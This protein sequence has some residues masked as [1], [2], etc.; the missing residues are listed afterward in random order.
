MSHHD[1]PSDATILRLIDGEC[2]TSERH[3]AS[4][5]LE[6]CPSCAQKRD[7]FARLTRRLTMTAAL[8]GAPAERLAARARLQARLSAEARRPV[9]SWWPHAVPLQWAAA[10][11]IIVGC[12]LMFALLRG[13]DGIPARVADAA[14]E[15][16]AR[17]VAALTPGW[18]LDVQARDLCTPPRPPAQEIGEAVRL[19]VLKNYRME[20]VPAD[21]YELDYL[22]TPE[23]GGAP[24]AR[25]LW[26]Q[27]YRSRVW[28]AA[29]KDQL[30]DL[31]PRLVCEGRIDLGTAQR[32]IAGDWVAAYRKYFHSTTPLAS[33]PAILGLLALVRVAPPPA[34][35]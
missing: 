9:R 25:N 19:A 33:R 8:S 15:I 5:H 34:G 2:S 26:P 24:D 4:A 30:E 28:N 22:I 1:H 6:Q 23:L 14:V 3:A 18:T 13:P 35:R 17:P 12:G 7:Q 10:V 16:D 11:A 31:L 29:V 21:Q 32:E 20:D 27:R